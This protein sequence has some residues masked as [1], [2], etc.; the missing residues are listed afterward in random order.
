[1]DEK[2]NF[3]VWTSFIFSMLPENACRTELEYQV[4]HSF[5]E[6]EL[7]YGNFNKKDK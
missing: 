5:G 2:T 1:L 7:R 6:K 4:N 3:F